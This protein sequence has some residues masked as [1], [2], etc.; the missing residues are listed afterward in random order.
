MTEAESE[1]LLDKATDDGEKSLDSATFLQLYSEHL[2]G[3]SNE[4]DIREAFQIFDVGASRALGSV[5]ICANHACVYTRITW[6]CH[7]G[8]SESELQYEM[9]F[10]G[11][12]LKM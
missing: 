1:K 11:V 6:F 12:F 9:G 8:G 2:E 4:D 3:R 5:I 10:W 7:Q